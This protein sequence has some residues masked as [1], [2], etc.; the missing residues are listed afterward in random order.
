MRRKQIRKLAW[1][2]K[3][4]GIA[5]LRDYML[6]F[7]RSP[8]SGRVMAGVKKAKGLSVYGVLYDIDRHA[9]ARIDKKEGAPKAR[10]R[11]PAKVELVSG[12]EVQCEVYVVENSQVE[13]ASPDRS[14]MESIC[15]AAQDLHLPPRYGDFLSYLK[16]AH[17]EDGRLLLVPTED[18]NKSK[19]MPLVRLYRSDA[20]ERHIGRFCAVQMVGHA[21]RN[22]GDGNVDEKESWYALG[23]VEIAKEKADVAAGTCQ[24]D[25]SLRNALGVSGHQCFGHQ[26]SV[27]RVSGRLSGGRLPSR[28]PLIQPRALVLR[29]QAESRHDAEKNYCV[30]HPELIKTLGLTEGDYAR[31]YAVTPGDKKGG[32]VKSKAITLRVFDGIGTSIE[33]LTGTVE[34]PRPGEIYL[35]AD[36]RQALGFQKEAFGVGE[37]GAPILVR[38]SLWHAFSSRS[39]IN[40]ITAFVG[41]DAISFLL[42][43]LLTLHGRT[44]AILSVVVALLITGLLSLID[45]RGRLRY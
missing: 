12:G 37:L 16:S 17:R 3:V 27:V 43:H 38:P 32:R 28:S 8:E 2:N 23:K 44:V 4:I 11:R 19:G 35:D 30:L 42:D 20:K 21:A 24:A 22:S 45:L 10:V 26:V 5:R 41:I 6:V 36:A 13:E 15:R 29:L 1:S 14:Y 33:P 34:Y 7:T 31:V 18:R 39:L 9:W 25:Q 40:G